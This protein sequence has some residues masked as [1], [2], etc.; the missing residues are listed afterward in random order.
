MGRRHVGTFRGRSVTAAD[1]LPWTRDPFDRLI[2]ADAIAA[3]TPLLTRDD[4]IHANC[5][6]AI[7]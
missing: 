5:D 4:T 1:S 6:V 3:A 7:W 2:V